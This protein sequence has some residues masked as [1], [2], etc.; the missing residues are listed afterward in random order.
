[1]HTRAEA[2]IAGILLTEI[3]MEMCLLSV[4]RRRDV[5]V[6]LLRNSTA[7]MLVSC[8]MLGSLLSMQF[9]IRQYMRLVRKGCAGACVRE[10]EGERRIE[11]EI[12]IRGEVMC[13][14]P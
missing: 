13:C 8:A 9:L 6:E 2:A 10:R 4:S 7:V 5:V 14:S 11:G 3:S 1:M 12:N